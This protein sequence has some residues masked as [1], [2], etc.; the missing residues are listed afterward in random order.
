MGAIADERTPVTLGLCGA[1][2]V[3]QKF[4]VTLQA[5]LEYVFIYYFEIASY[6]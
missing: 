5:S 2:S 1:T 6:I 3:K 4:L